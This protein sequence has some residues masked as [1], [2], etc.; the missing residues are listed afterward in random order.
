MHCTGVCH[1]DLHARKGD[2][3][4]AHKL[5]LIGGHEGVAHIVANGTHAID[6]PI[7]I[8]DRVGVKWLAESCLECEQCRKG[9][10]QSCAKSKLSGYAVDR[11]YSQV[12]RFS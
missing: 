2:W 5:P 3:R 11:I 8:G 6:L 9:L 4:L 12:V 7:K 10:E 1:A